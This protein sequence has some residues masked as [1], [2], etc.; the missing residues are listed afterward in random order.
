MKNQ[1]LRTMALSVALSTG[2]LAAAG[3]AQ[4]VDQVLR[5]GAQKVAAAQASQKRVDQI[6]DTTYDL[7]QQF[8]T[9]NKQIE[10]LRVYN[11]QLERQIANQVEIMNDLEESIE[12]ATVMERQILPLAVRMLDALEQFVKLDLP[13]QRDER[14]EQIRHVRENLDSARFTTAEKFRQVLELYDIEGEYSRTID[15]FDGLVQIDGEDRKVTFLRVGRIAL[16]FQTPDQKVTG[17]WDRE[18]GS[19]Q[20]A[21]EFR[22]AVAQG[23]RIAKKQAAIDIM[24]LPIPAPEAAQ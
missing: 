18:T 9:V 1:R 11:A 6:A 23:I 19:W 13:F 16:L 17:V 4:E 14:L 2:L 21:D 15:Q 7:L 3:Q 5:E 12:N 10:G 24:T 8:K 20:T 22:A